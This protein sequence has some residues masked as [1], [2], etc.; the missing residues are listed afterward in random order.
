MNKHL[1][2]R[3]LTAMVITSIGA[4]A[5]AAAPVQPVALEQSVTANTQVAAGQADQA[6]RQAA[7]AKLIAER[8]ADVPPA[9]REELAQKI[10]QDMQKLAAKAAKQKE[11]DPV[12]VV[13]HVASNQ[14]VELNLPKTVQM[15]LDYNRDIKMAHYSLKSAEYAIDEARASKMPQLD[16][17]WS[18]SRSGGASTNPVNQFTNGLSLTLPLYTGGKAEGN[19]AV[20]Q[21]SKTS[22]QEEIL[23]VEQATK[24]NAISAYYGLLAYEELQDVYDESVTNLQGH[25]DNVS[26]RYNVGT[27]AKVDVLSSDVSLANAK[28][29]AVTAAN[30]VANAEAS[31]NNILGLPVQ[32]KLVLADHRLPFNEYTISLEEAIDYA[33]KYRPDVLQAGLA[34]QEAEEAIGIAEAGHRPTVSIGASNGWKDTSFPGWDNRDWAITGGVSYSLYDGG[35]TNAKIKEAKQSLL[36]ARE[37]EQKVR[38]S[39]QL[40]VKKAYLNIRSAAQKVEATQTVINQAEENFKIQSVRYQAGVGINLDVLDAQ[41]SLNEARTNNIQA[42]YDY[43]VGIATLEQAMGVDVR[44]GVVIPSGTINTVVQ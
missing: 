13:G 4:A 34:V 38:E 25:V 37:N 6:V 5:S 21:L 27:V 10:Q 43:N 18:S 7:A 11:A 39:V 9:L 19:I 33:M 1:Y 36:T 42:L 24:L 44:S 32:T 16:Y 8:N 31:L 29:D 12:I 20:A 23:R 35:A 41:L 30:N 2:T 17:T 26:A 15:A 40:E 22:A 14:A 3:I 28:T